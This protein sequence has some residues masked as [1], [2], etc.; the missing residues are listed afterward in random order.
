M[1][2]CLEF[3]Y[4]PFSKLYN[5]MTASFKKKNGTAC[6]K[7]TKKKIKEVRPDDKKNTCF[8]NHEFL[9]LTS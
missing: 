1:Y 3:I 6:F 4:V 2:E 8:F 5:K 7:T 9:L